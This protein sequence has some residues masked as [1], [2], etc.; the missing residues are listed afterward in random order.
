MLDDAV[1]GRQAKPRAFPLLLRGKEW[2][3]NSRFDV[4]VHPVPGVTHRQHNVVSG[5]QG[6]ARL[7]VHLIDLHVFRFD[8]QGSPARHRIGGI[9]NQ[10][11][12]HLLDLPGIGLHPPEWLAQVDPVLDV[13]PQQ[14]LQQPSHLH[15]QFIQV[16]N[17][18]LQHLPAAEGQ[19]LSRQQRRPVCNAANLF[20]VSANGV[21]WL[22]PFKSQI[23]VSLDYCEQIIEIVRYAAGKSSQCIHFLRLPK[24]LFELFPLLL[25]SLL[26]IPHA[27]KRPRHTRHFV[28]TGGC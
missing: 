4:V 13:L 2:L 11:Q 14:A 10:V 1:D 19:Q 5:R 16:E 20:A 26:S 17:L 12:E 3:E 7:R 9:H 24:L 28:S 15:D 22:D 8:G 18:G 27:F 21:R 25:V 23:A 6:R